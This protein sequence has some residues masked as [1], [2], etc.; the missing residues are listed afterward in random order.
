MPLIIKL[1]DRFAHEIAAYDP[2]HF[3]TGYFV[4]LPEVGNRYAGV[5]KLHITDT[6]AVDSRKLK[7]TATPLRIV[8]LPASGSLK[9]ELLC[10]LFRDHVWCTC[11]KKKVV[12][13][14]VNLYFQ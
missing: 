13:L 6:D 4:R 11:I 8:G 3:K 7:T 1:P 5:E 14:S 10:Q 9:A 2:I 12:L